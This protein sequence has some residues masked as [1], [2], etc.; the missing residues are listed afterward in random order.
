MLG[1]SGCPPSALSANCA[2]IEAASHILMC[3]RLTR[4]LDS[5]HRSQARGRARFAAGVAR[6]EFQQVV[7]NLMVNGMQAAKALTD[8]FLIRSSLDQA[9]AALPDSVPSASRNDGTDGAAR[10]ALPP[11][12][13]TGR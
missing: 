4:D 9:L 2:N 3:R 1:T 5:S 10:L 12:P 7:I 8:R 13:G 6:I 11:M